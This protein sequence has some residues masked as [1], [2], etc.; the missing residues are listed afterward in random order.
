M[1]F[2]KAKNEM[3]FLKCGIYGFAGSGKSFTATQIAI[4]LHKYIGSK[5]PI[6]FLDTETGSDFLISRFEDAKID[7]QVAKT[8]AYI[9][10]LSAINEAEK[11]KSILIIDSI[12]HFWTELMTA[13]LTRNK[14]TR[15]NLH[16]I[17]ILKQEWKQYT[18]KFIAS[19]LHIIMC[20]R[21]GWDF[22]H[23][24]NE[25][26][27]K[28]L[29]KVGTKM[30]AEAETGYEPSLSL[31]MERVRIE[32][33]KIGST[34]KH[35]CWVLKDRFDKING[36]FF[37]NPKFEVFLPHISLLNIGGKHRALEEGRTSEDMFGN[38]DKSTSEY[39][40]QKDIALE[41]IKDTLALRF[42]KTDE[43]KKKQIEELQRIFGTSSKTAIENMPLETLQA[44]LKEIKGIN[45]V[46]GHMEDKEET[47]GKTN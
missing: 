19:K 47:N 3:C 1:L 16:D 40:K 43:Q 17:M 24:E 29:T 2:K 31:E 39:Y 7:L 37:D 6:F 28:E 4:G 5:E 25:D 27:I 30:R 34:Y 38:T 33:G 15:L 12:S 41:E 8:R 22:D 26:G 32:Q 44:G 14:K 13:Y 20:G 11:K 36:R 18:D 10:L 21:A 35:R 23:I 9:D 42:G 45:K 46:E